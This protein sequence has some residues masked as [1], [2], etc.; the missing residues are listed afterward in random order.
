M[1]KKVVS[2]LD[3]RASKGVAHTVK[4]L[5]RAARDGKMIPPD[6]RKEPDEYRSL[7][8]YDDGSCFLH[9]VTVASM[10]RR[11]KNISVMKDV[12]L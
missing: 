6:W 1:A 7:T 9:H 10:A 8:V 4:L 2:I 12:D 11:L 5:E 3:Y